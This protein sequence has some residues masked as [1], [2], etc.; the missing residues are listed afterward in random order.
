MLAPVV[1]DPRLVV[2]NEEVFPAAIVVVT[3]LVKVSTL[4]CT[5]EQATRLIFETGEVLPEPITWG[6]LLIPTSLYE[7]WFAI[8]SF[9]KFLACWKA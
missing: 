6:P 8:A 9:I 7:S 4:F 5:S 2:G 1:K 3:I